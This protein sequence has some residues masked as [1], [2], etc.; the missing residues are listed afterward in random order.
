MGGVIS[1]FTARPCGAK[2]STLHKMYYQ[3]LLTEQNDVDSLHAE[4]REMD[5]PRAAGAPQAGADRLKGPESLTRYL[6]DGVAGS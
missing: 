1:E 6:A 4:P 2:A 5:R 3:A